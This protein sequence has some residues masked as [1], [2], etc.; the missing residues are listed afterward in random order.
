V[1]RNI[2]HT[3]YVSSSI[4]NLDVPRP[5]LPALTSLRFFAALHVVFFHFLAFKI[6]PSEGWLG[7]I[8]SI[9]YVGVSFFFVLSG[10]ILVYTYAGRNT[11][12]RDFWRARFAR[13]YPAFAFSLLL[14]GPFFFFATLMLN[15]P[16]FA[17]FATHLKLVVLLVPFLLQAW[18]PLAALAW[19][20]VAWSLSDEAFF[21]L[22]F[23]FLKKRFLK[24]S[25]SGL[26]GIAL[27]CW[28]VSLAM[29]WTYVLRNPDHLQVIDADV[30]NAF[31][32]N[33]VKFHPFARL[34]E[35]LLGMACGAMFLKSRKD[36]KP[37]SSAKLALPLVLAGLVTTA[38]V[39]HFSARIPYT[40]LHTSLLAPAFAAIIF[41]SALQP[42]WGAPLNWKPLV[43]LGDASYS[44][45]LLH[46]FFLGPFFFTLTGVPRHRGPGWYFLYFVLA[47][48]ISGLVY[49][50]IE[51]PSRRKLR[52]GPL[53]S[54]LADV[55]AAAPS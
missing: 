31:W 10:F 8:S 50:F 29:S 49:R 45:Y 39:A 24:I 54:A 33:A 37:G 34:P 53:R 17:W 21:Y 38:T 42:R 47:L 3:R 27:A 44:L 16:F 1:H 12:A 46:S 40:V 51:E 36:A 48:G 4:M 14:T 26:A 20:S 28:A 43:F 35:F 2:L 5:R 7:Q 13:I 18:V 6:V 55:P 52:G 30:L 32:L 15:V 41:G 23:P 25:S 19:N 9:G 11:P 22:L